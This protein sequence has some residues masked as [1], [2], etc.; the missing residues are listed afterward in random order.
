MSM[1]HKKL[2]RLVAFGVFLASIAVYLKTL[3]PTIVFWDV[4]EHCTASY[5]LQVQHPPG[6]PLLTLVLRIASMIP[7][8]AD[9]GVRMILFNVFASCAV[10]VLLYLITVRCILMWRSQ[11]ET[12]FDAISVYGAAAVGAMAL[13]FSTTFWFNTIEVET[14]N[15]SLL[16]TAL[17]IWLVL[18]WYE[19]AEDKHSD[20]YLLM[21]TF[22]VG[23]TAGIH[24]HGLLGFVVAILLVY[25]RFYPKTLKEFLF[26]ADVI[27]FG[28]VAVLIFMVAYPGIVKWFP[29]M[30]DSDVFG[31]HSSLW[32]GVAIGLVVAA[33][34][35][36]W[37]S[38]KKNNRL[39]NIGA[40]AFLFILLGY[41]TYV[42]IVIRANAGTPMNQ[43]DP[44]TLRRLVAYLEREQYGDT[45]LVNR[46]FSM[47]ADKQENFKKYTSDW[48]YMWTYQIK[49]MYWRY[50]AWNFIGKESD[51]QDADW[52]FSQLYAIPFLVGL[53][54][55]FYHW[56]KHQ[57][58][59]FI[60]TVFFLLSGLA[61]AI[62]FNMQ[63]SQPRERDYFFVYS[64]FAFCF[65]IGLGTLA[66]VDYVREKIATANGTALAYGAL[67]L[68]VVLVPANMLRTNYKPMNRSGHYLAWDYSYNLLQSV[69]KD[70]LLITAG[71][72][73]TFPLWYLQDVEGI[74][75]DV[76]IVNLS[77]ANMDYYI[78]QLKHARPYGSKPVPISL[79]DEQIEGIQPMEY[80]TQMIR[81]PVPKFALD[82][83]TSPIV[84][85]EGGPSAAAAEADKAIVDTLKFV[86][87]ATLRFGNRSA[88]RVQ[89]ILVFD[90]VRSMQWERPVYFAITAGGDDSKIGLRDY[91]ELEGLAYRL[92]PRK[93]Q[94]YWAAVNEERTRAHLFTDVKQPS[95]EQAYGCLWR[96][97]QDSTIK[98][99]ENQRRMITSYRQP[100]YTLALFLS[101]VKNKPEEMSAV[102]DRMEQV[103]PRHLHPMDFRL[104]A[105]MAVFYGI[106][107]NKVRQ[108]EFFRELIDELGPTVDSGFTEQFSQYH[109]LAIL[110]QAYQ[111]LDE[112]DKALDA[113]QR[114]QKAYASTPGIP[115]FANAKKAEIEALKRGATE[116]QKAGA[117][118]DSV[119]R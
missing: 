58:M 114:I 10:I 59:A 115:E 80:Q 28:V 109:P 96:G 48:D 79:P 32:I 55:C 27:K 66:I 113:V 31:I 38:T 108:R 98:F 83:R 112:Y 11:P 41:S 57:K 69:E 110:L 30:L 103:V 24:I 49:H 16:F 37:S 71:D 14:R 99:D 44:S 65:W 85:V 101:N 6:S 15:T 75:R 22:L 20:L 89:D 21:I 60:M 104:K 74:R 39:L 77:L 45:P 54:G 36:V 91:L 117:P 67:A 52:R 90:I 46:R 72:N 62:Y 87:P 51:V 93:R 64:V 94:A 73:D 23:L 2:N 19:K 86:M 56:K 118:R 4:S 13:A 105:D 7:L 12:M 111:A 42:T 102:L 40:L 1:N 17:I 43:N 34:Y 3:P 116:A 33:I 106:S 47:E 95:K 50:I 53:I 84:A 9:I 8:S 119:A 18:I 29:S 82:G 63:E 92:V 76:R 61:L 35:F 107:G 26:S 97:L 81:I 5:F 78:L 88:L 70:A 68:V 100:F 25:L